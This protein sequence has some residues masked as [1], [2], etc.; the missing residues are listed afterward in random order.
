MLIAILVKQIVLKMLSGT[1]S[2]QNNTKYATIKL[3]NLLSVGNM[4][5]IM[6]KAFTIVPYVVLHFLAPIQN[7]RVVQAGLASSMK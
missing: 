4:T 3:Q 2:V 7:L 5:I 6:K 1:T